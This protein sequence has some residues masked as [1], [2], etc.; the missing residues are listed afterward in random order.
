MPAARSAAR[1]PDA[2]AHLT[3]ALEVS[4]L[5][6]RF[7]RGEGAVQALDGLGLA[8]PSG[9]IFGLLGAN[10]AGKSTLMRIVAGLVFADAGEVRLFGAPAG[11]ESRRRLGAAVEAPAFWPF[12]SA[13]E[14]LGMLARASGAEADVAALLDRVGLGSAA[15]R[16][17]GGFSLGMKQRL[18]IAA[19]LVGAPDLLLLDEPANGLDPA[20]TAELR[21]LLRRL[22]DDDGLTI[23]LSSHL[24]DEV[25]RLC[26][27]IA[28]IDAGRLVAEAEVKALP[29]EFLWLD[30]RPIERALERIG[31]AG[32]RDGEGVSVAIAR[33]EAPALIA[34]LVGDGLELHE[35][36]WVRPGLEA[37]FLARTGGGR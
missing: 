29:G 35:A 33:G 1:H 20:G 15:H 14:T 10:G 21:L 37:L 22:A 36:R 12:L 24:L 28:I 27:R 11:S 2:S 9:G 31:A 34:A 6:K 7:G 4:A 25:E 8:V 17:V 30:A 5:S 19:A 32:R 3:P 18:A 23:I 13:A 16:P 26:D